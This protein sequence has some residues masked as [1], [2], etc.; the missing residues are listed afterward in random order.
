MPAPRNVS[1]R[2]P[3][4]AKVRPA[5][6]HDIPEIVA[7]WGE[8]AQYHTSLDPSFAPSARWQDEYR[9]FIRALIGRDDALAVVAVSEEQIVGYAV[10][11]IS[12]LPGFFERRRRGYIHDVV[13]R[14]PFRRRGIGTGLVDAL[15]EWMR[16]GG[17]TTV[18]L[19]VSTRNHDA[20]RFWSRRGFSAYMVHM[21]RDTE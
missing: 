13:T 9:Q 18:E 10:G 20:V 16:A 5:T 8:L 14:E 11:R 7:I 21:K 6:H 4:Q 12:M 15:L 1:A 3:S 2:A 19:T 17:V